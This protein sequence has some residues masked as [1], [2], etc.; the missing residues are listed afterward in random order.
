MALARGGLLDDD[1]EIAL[2]HARRCVELTRGHVDQLAVTALATLAHAQYLRGDVVAARE[3][4]EQAAAQ[5]AASPPPQGLVQALAL[6]ALLE[7]DAG[8]PHAAEGKA[9]HAVALARELGLAGIMSMGIAHHALGQALLEL[10]RAQDAE[11]ELE[12]AE[13]LRRAPE[14]RLDHIH[15][16]LVLT[17]A[18]VARGRLTVAASELELAREQ[19][20]AF[21]DTGRLAA[22]ADEVAGRLEQAQA[23]AEKTVE[24]PSPAE[25]SVLRLLASDLSQREIGTRAV[26][27]D[28]YG[29][30]AHPQPLQ[31]A[32]RQ[33]AQG[34]DPSGE[35][36]RTDRPPRFT[37]V[38]RTRRGVRRPCTCDGGGRE[39]LRLLHRRRRRARTALRGG[40]RID[41]A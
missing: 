36:P 13:T 38:I 5:P 30:D 32:G 39:G 3:A 31:Q 27:V 25:L 9:R 21:S 2:G 26:S 41:A 29:Q 24:P 22:L 16:L 10:G 20:D 23:G 35:R 11:R 28:E 4:A 14:P 8:H 7:C 12:R 19:L 6:L 17:Q 1:L 40:V 15:S 37:W 18:R 34:G 33:L